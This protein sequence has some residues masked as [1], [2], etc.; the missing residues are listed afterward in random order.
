MSVLMAAILAWGVPVQ[1]KQE[2]VVDELS[3][4]ID[5]LLDDYSSRLRK[6]IDAL[7]KE[8][9]KDVKFATPPGPSNWKAELQKLATNLKDDGVTGDLK[10]ALGTAKGLDA[11]A[12]I[13]GSSGQPPE[14][15]FAALFD[16]GADG[17]L[18]I[19]KERE[20]EFKQ[21]LAGMAGPVPSTPQPTFGL[22]IDREGFT[23]KDREALGL[24]A[25]Q[26]MRLSRVSDDGPAAKAGLKAGD[27]MVKV[28]DDE[29]TRA[30]IGEI[31]TK[32]FKPGDKVT[33]EYLRDGKKAS[34]EVTVGQK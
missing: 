14:A 22:S 25:D 26:G 33:V 29:I 6:E 19:K 4:K 2:K 20:E 31:L 28:G 13:F 24:K 8:E 32:K 21:A 7:V 5:K 11:F 1:D 27:V 23:D 16:Q 34:A 9:L 3:K 15:I 30:N 18:A 12:R 17:K 10:K